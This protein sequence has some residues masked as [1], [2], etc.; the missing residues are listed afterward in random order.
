M[1]R[2]EAYATCVNL[3]FNPSFEEDD[4]DR[5]P[6]GWCVGWLDTF[7]RMGRAE[8]YPA[9]THWENHVKTGQY[10]ALISVFA[11]KAGR[12]GRP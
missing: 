5:V 8:W 6:D 10:S 11:P 2:L 12:D 9:K 7:D 3:V 1:H 4:G